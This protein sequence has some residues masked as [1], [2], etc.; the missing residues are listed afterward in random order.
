MK[1]KENLKH[2]MKPK[3]NLKHGPTISEFEQNSKAD[4]TLEA[5]EFTH[6][7]QKRRK[8]KREKN[9]TMA[10][11]E[12]LQD[13]DDEKRDRKATKSDDA[14]VPVHLWLERMCDGN[15]FGWS[16]NTI[17]RLPE[18][19]PIFQSF[20]LRI[21]KRRLTKSFT[22]YLNN[23]VMK[24]P[25]H[26]NSNW[27]LKST[28]GFWRWD[29][30][31]QDRY[32]NWWMSRWVKGR[33]D[34]D[35]GRDALTRGANSSWWGWDDGSHPFF[36]R[37]PKEY[38]LQM[39]DGIR[40]YAQKTLPLYRKAQR[41]IADEFV[42]ERVIKKLN[43][44]RNNRYIQGGYVKSL[45]SFFA[46]PKGDSDIR[47]V[48]DASV[49]GLNDSLWAPRFAMPSLGTHLRAVEGGTYMGD[50][51]IGDCFLNFILHESVRP[52]AGVDLTHYAA[53]TGEETIW[54]RWTRAPMGLTTSPYQ[55]CQ[56]VAF[57][58]EVVLGHYLTPDNIFGWEY[59]RL[60]LPGDEAYTPNLP[61]VSKVRKDGKI[62]CD[63]FTFVDDVRVTG[64]TVMECWLAGRHA[65]SKLNFLGIQ[66]AARKRRKCS[67][68]PGAWSGGIIRT[69][70]EE[71]R[72]L[73]SQEKWDKTK[74]LLEELRTM[75]ENHAEALERKRLE[76]IRGF[77]NYV[78]QTYKNMT[79]YLNGL[80][81]T[82]DSW[83]PNR[84][85]EGWR[86]AKETLVV[87]EAEW[88]MPFDKVDG[89]TLVKGV[90][91]LSNDV[92]ALQSLTKHDRPILRRVRCSKVGQVLYGFGDASGAGFGATIQI[93]NEIKYEY[94]QWSSQ[95]TEEE[96]S[97]WR[98]L[99]NLVSTLQR[100]AEKKELGDCEIFL[101][102]DNTTAE[103][104]FWKGSSK[105]R[106][107]FE[108]ILT[109]KELEFTH[110]FILHVIHVSGKRMIKQG[111]DGLSRGDHSEGVMTGQP[112][113]TFV[114]L[115]LSALTRSSCLKTWVSKAT[116]DM[117]F[118]WLDPRGWFTEVNK[119]GNF[120][121]APPP[122]AGDV[123]V[124]LLGKARLKRPNSMHLV[125]IPRLMTGR[126]RRHLTRGT[127]VYFKV[128]WEEEWD[129]DTHFEPVLIFIALPY[130][131]HSPKIEERTKLVA[132][133]Q[134][135]LS[136][137]RLR[138]FSGVRRRNLLRE[139]LLKARQLCPL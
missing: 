62:S 18:T 80:H 92:R 70:N 34:I 120:I 52:Y 38:R 122:A 97:N 20:L 73:I 74:A 36:W 102:T 93:G 105:S 69:E 99:S 87:H 89:P 72:V 56:A 85:E 98:E 118:K 114:P 121:W 49:S 22:T 115:H 101:F 11:M 104:S 25:K 132:H 127:D 78:C 65:A 83:R 2:G 6:R 106:K 139:F 10:S 17:E 75:L 116:K 136:E 84:D 16:K 5:E 24:V 28:D 13:V 30:G 67:R 117:Y 26:K 133:L 60:N 76:Q 135:C 79:P 108:L 42:K 37:W 45:T 33:R 7:D 48:Y 50:C 59:V 68:A 27:V 107:L 57:A 55:A 63:L 81:M 109:L 14:A 35:A 29:T 8:L 1:P 88:S 82:I 46:V 86:K 3:E 21:W 54:E 53:K 90:P 43:K 128:D 129:L 58:E 31:G 113:I 77:L 64:S 91:R 19:L 124:D 103:A 51:D 100:L 96:S 126:W 4:T 134:R 40:V 138:S 44:V 66:D 131:S 71:V 61:W 123:V 23:E 32:R 112:M 125:V 130:K 119:S 137:A 12:I 47:M 15:K 39:R 9:D 94:G 95:I 111:T 110:D 41:D